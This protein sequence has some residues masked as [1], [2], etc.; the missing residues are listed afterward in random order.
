MIPIVREFFRGLKERHELDSIIPELLTAIGFEV[1]SRPMIGP[2]QYGADVAAIGIDEDGVRK[3][4][5][6]VI[7]RV[8]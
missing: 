2:R 3:L 5:L 8:I 6:F 4:F 1:I 7:K